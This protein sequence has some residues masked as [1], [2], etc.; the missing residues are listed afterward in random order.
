MGHEHDRGAGPGTDGSPGP[1]GAESVDQLGPP[2]FG[3]WPSPFSAEAVAA[4][5]ISR[6]GLH[7]DGDQ[8]V[9]TESR[10]AQDGRQVVVRSGPD[11]TSEIVSPPGVSVRSRVHEYG[12]G[13][14][15]CVH[16]V[17]YYVDQ[18][19]Q[20]WY[21]F[22]PVSDQTPLALTA[23]TTGRSSSRRAGDGRLT[24]DG[25]WLVFVEEEAERA[26]TEHRIVAVATDGAGRQEVLVEGGGF[27]AAPR[28]SPDGAWLSWV[29]WDH[30]SMSWDSSELRLARLVDDGGSIRVEGERTVAGGGPCSVGQ[31]RWLSDGS[32]LFADDRTGWWL[33]Y[34]LRVDLTG[35]SGD[36]GGTSRSRALIDEPA[37]FHA[38]DWLLGQATMAELPDAS[39]VSRSRRN[40]TDRLVRLAP[41]P[42]AEHGP[43]S[44]SVIDQP[45]VTVTG[46][47]AT[48]SGRLALIGSTPFEA[49]VVVEVHPAGGGPP[50]RLSADHG[51]PAEGRAPGRGASDLRR[52]MTTE[53]STAV[54][55]VR[56]HE[57]PTAWGVVPGLFV[58]PG[59]PQVGTP[60]NG[61][62]PLV[63][64]CHGGPTASAEPGF[65]PVVQFFTSRGLAVAVV[66]YRGSAGHGRNYRRSLDGGWG[67]LDVD[68]CIA[69]ARGLADAGWVDGDRMAIRGT[70]A[71]GLT[72]LGA[73]I[74][75]RCFRGAVAWYGVTDL[76][77]LATDTHD[78]ESH[79]LETLVGKWPQAM[80][81]YRS[82]SPLRHPD[83]VTGSVLLLQGTDDPVVPADQSIRFVRALVERGADCRI[84]LFDGESHG[85]RRADTIAS[86]L[87]MELGFY[88]RL[89]GEDD[90]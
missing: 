80:P 12:G 9:W 62:P 11:G 34:R 42:S 30:P 71:G 25:R 33:P 47:A 52:L 59:N 90:G 2:R 45:C 22:D 1:G 73:L 50:H 54:S 13:A 18:D 21:R 78:F 32:L 72:A 7:A 41:P 70:S 38:P 61:R 17:V 6:G 4:G 60:V 81:V 29:A 88:R 51:R 67:A 68:D 86:A 66:D 16:G 85:F 23:G 63:V 53:E 49:Q 56:S 69:Y 57:V 35:P 40:G 14:A 43:W 55:I 10:P 46:V 36:D 65:D 77:A 84:H 19:D 64:F 79:Y 58:S 44:A 39:I 82:R 28:P 75:S 27:V 74:R 48:G 5:R 87:T 3:W 89:F 8:F 83:L 76:E 37:E 26:R 24:G 20:G 31:P 15:L